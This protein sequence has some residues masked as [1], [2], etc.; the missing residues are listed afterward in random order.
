MR[1]VQRMSQRVVM[2]PLLQQAIH[3]LQLSTLELKEVVEQEPRENPLLEEVQAENEPTAELPGPETA[4]L[5]PPPSESPPAK[6][7]STVDG[8][9]SDDLPFDLNQAMFDQPEERTPVSTEEGEGVT[10]HR[11]R[12]RGDAREREPA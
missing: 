12:S 5:Q 3:L 6:E 11:Q 2:T 10:L 7:Q 8:E 1:L 4:D 9:K